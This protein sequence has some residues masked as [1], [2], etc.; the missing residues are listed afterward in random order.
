M[1]ARTHFSGFKNV[2]GVYC[3]LDSLT[4]VEYYKDTDENRGTIL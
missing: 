2:F 3:L 4:P 1:F